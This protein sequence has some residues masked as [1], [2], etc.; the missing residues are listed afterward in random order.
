MFDKE[1]YIKRRKILKEQVGNGLILLLGSEESSM[2]Y[3]DNLY[4]FRQDSTFLYFF[5]IDQPGLTA[6]IDIDNDKEILFGDDLTTEQMVWTGYKEPLQSIA[7]RVGIPEVKTK[8]HLNAEVAVALMQKRKIHFLPPYRPEQVAT[9]K[10]LLG[11]EPLIM[12]NLASVELIHAVVNQRSYKSP[13]EIAEIVNAVNTTVDMQLSAIKM[14]KEGMT[15]AQLA[16]NIQGIAIGAGGN[17]SFPT[18]LTMHGEIL[19]NSYSQSVLSDGSMVLCDCGAETGMHYAGDLTR[20]FPVS[21]KFT[22][23]Q[24]ELYDIVFTAHKAAVELLKP[25]ILFRDV[26]LFACEKLVEGLHQLGLMK[27]D[28][29]E[30]VALGAHALFFP[31]G[32]GHMMGLD[33]HDM[34]NLGE[35]YV[36]YNKSI[37]QSTQFGLKSLRLGK[38]LEEGFVITVEP[39]LYFN[40]DLI[41][42]WSAE[43]KFESF[44]NYDRLENF[45]N[46]S[47]IRIEED[48]LITTQGSQLLGKP[49]AKTADEIEELRL[50]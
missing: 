34:E 50:T 32:L 18:I 29:K 47:G 31:C 21:K 28:I 37:K 12:P 23:I 45:K 46:V 38:E 3:K 27:G 39:G 14:A 10:H 33:T 11:I 20:T 36:G 1:I 6:L 41:N 4:P 42:E 35:Q 44:I 49:L 2:N 15:E 5:G 17:L 9:L 24:R 8:K 25:G 30:T 26:H 48:F 19:H 7:D 13:E 22:N 16:G 40:P 43:K